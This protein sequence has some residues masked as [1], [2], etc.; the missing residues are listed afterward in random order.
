VRQDEDLKCLER[1]IRDFGGSS[2][3]LL[4]EHLQAARRDL[5]G[6]MRG[7]YLASLQFAKESVSCIADK[8]VRAETTK[9]LQ[10]LLSRNGTSLA[11]VV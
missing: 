8:G 4:R 2:C 1:L 6:S 9:I 3:D 5:L 10:S 7:E 11:P